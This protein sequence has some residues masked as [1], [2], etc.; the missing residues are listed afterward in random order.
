[1][2]LNHRYTLD[3]ETAAVLA[4][5]AGVNLELHAEQ[6]A[7]GVYD[8]LPDAVKHGKLTEVHWLCCDFWMEFYMLL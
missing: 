3:I 1:M 5:Q 8:W 4:V 6:Y 2:I 7:R